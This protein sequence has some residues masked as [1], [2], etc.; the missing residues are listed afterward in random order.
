MAP[1]GYAN[2]PG[3]GRLFKM[4]N[5]VEMRVLETHDCSWSDRR[6]DREIIV[7][8]RLRHGD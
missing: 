2:C 5:E 1:Y 3:C 4:N 7:L 8:N 6:L